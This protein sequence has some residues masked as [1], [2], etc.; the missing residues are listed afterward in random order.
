VILGGGA[1]LLL[2]HVE[3]QYLVNDVAKIGQI[4]GQVKRITLRT[5]ALGDTKGHMHLIGRADHDRNQHHA[6][7]VA[8][9]L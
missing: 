5:T 6:R 3:Q 1:V 7:P 9:R 4:S 8:S 2:D